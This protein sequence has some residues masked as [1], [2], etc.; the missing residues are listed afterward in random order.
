M[1]AIV[2]KEYQIEKSLNEILQIVSVNIFEQVPLNELL[3]AGQAAPRQENSNSQ[4]QKLLM[5]NN[6]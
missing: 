1:A 4:S 5:F 2:K 3:A 6:I